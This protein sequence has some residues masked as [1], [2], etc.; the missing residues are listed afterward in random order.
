[1]DATIKTVAERE[2]LE[3]K[4]S[5]AYDQSWKAFKEDL[6]M[7]VGTAGL[8]HIFDLRKANIDEVTAEAWK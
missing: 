7:E 6:F 1:M 2:A 5:A 4:I 8:G 3:K